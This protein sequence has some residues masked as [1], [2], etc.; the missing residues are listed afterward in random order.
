MT[1][2]D[3]NRHSVTLLQVA[4]PKHGKFVSGQY[5]TGKSQACYT[6]D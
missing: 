1:T 6:A 3:K 2:V 5:E 4:N